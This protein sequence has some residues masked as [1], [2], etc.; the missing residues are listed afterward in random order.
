[1]QGKRNNRCQAFTTLPALMQRVQTRIRLCP[2]PISAF[3]GRRLTFQRRLD[4]L[5]A[6]EILLPNCGPLPQMVQ[7]CAMTNSITYAFRRNMRVVLLCKC[8]IEEG[9]SV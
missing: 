2:P 9:D 5:C 7:I 1:M 6:C 4:T 3:T 8:A